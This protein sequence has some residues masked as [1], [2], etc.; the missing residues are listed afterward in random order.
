MKIVKLTSENIKK[1]VAVQITPKGNVIRITG[2]NGQGKTSI[3]D[4]IF[5]LLGGKE[6]IQG[7]PIRKG[8]QSAKIE[9]E[10]SGDLDLGDIIVRR[11]FTEHVPE[12]KEG[13][14]VPPPEIRSTLIIENKK[15]ARFQ[16]PQSMLD[17]LIGRLAFD[18]LEFMRMDA[19]K[20]FETMRALTGVDL[21]AFDKRRAELYAERTAA[22]RVRDSLAARFAALVVPE[23]APDSETPSADVV[24]R[25]NA[26]NELKD[27]KE[28][29]AERYNELIASVVDRHD[30]IR[31]ATDRIK[32]LQLQIS[33]AE[34]AIAT[35]Q[36]EITSIEAQSETVKAEVEAIVVPDIAAIQKEIKELDGKNKAARAKQDKAKL[37]DELDAAERNCSALTES[38][39]VID[40]EKAAKISEAKF[41]LP[42]LG[43]GDGV[44]M[45]EGLPLDQASSAGQLRVSM[46]M[47]MAL[48]PKLRLIRIT[49]GSLLDS[50]SLKIVEEMAASEDF[51]VW[52]ESVDETGKVGI[53][54]QDGQVVAVNEPAEE[55]PA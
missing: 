19:K 34:Q 33:A 55:V 43:F 5:W 14:P 29:A 18:P 20:Q 22:N 12:H 17:K 13:E 37:K 11:T 25:L 6:H 7:Q 4:S 30:T 53:V 9:A 8:Q 52:M 3:L 28:L 38:I 42:G 39:V 24:A 54:I 15:G 31:E 21:S 27:K 10:L 45:Y 46:A 36:E 47:A 44:V 51:Q 1:L 49:D 40:G 2:K 16:S 23:N 35:A 32:Q 41:P 50:E 26:A 48:N